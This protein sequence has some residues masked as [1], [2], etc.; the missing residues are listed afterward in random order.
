MILKMVF[1]LHDSLSSLESK[2]NL[3]SPLDN[4]CRVAF[5]GTL[6]LGLL[7]RVESVGTMCRG[8]VRTPY[9]QECT[10]VSYFIDN[11]GLGQRIAAA[12]INLFLLLLRVIIERRGMLIIVE[13]PIGRNPN[14]IANQNKTLYLDL[15]FFCICSL[16][17]CVY[18]PN[19]T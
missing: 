12:Y 17:R 6:V 9:R 13:S 5:E 1:R 11:L 7:N 16:F 15:F 2:R 10:G 18:A 8:A 14:L 19:L 4:S 3:S